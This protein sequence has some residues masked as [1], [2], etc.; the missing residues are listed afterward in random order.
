V[1]TQLYFVRL[2]VHYGEFTVV[3]EASSSKRAKSLA[4]PLY[5]DKNWGTAEFWELYRQTSTVTEV[6]VEGRERIVCVGGHQE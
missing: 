2:K 3:V 5:T 4:K 6:R 1:Q